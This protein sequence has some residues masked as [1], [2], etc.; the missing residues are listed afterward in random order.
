MV[1][2]Y[3]WVGWAGGVGKAS[4][5]DICWTCEKSCP[6]VEGV[7]QGELWVRCGGVGWVGWGGVGWDE[8]GW[9]GVVG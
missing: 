4:E 8:M 9:G 1:V 3:C 7:G 6:K 5:P 2:G